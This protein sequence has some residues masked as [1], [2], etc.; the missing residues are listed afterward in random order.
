[1][2]AGARLAA[3]E[4]CALALTL[5]LVAA[6][7]LLSRTDLAAF[8]DRFAA[9]DG[10]VETSGAAALLAGAAL[11]GIRAWRSRRWR[12]ARF[13]GACALVGLGL[14]AA[15]GEELSWGQRLLRFAPPDLLARHNAQREANLH[16]LVIAGVQLK[17]FL[18]PVI[19]G[20][21]VAYLLLGP[22]AWLAAAGVRRAA[23]AGAVPVPRARHGVAFGLAYLMVLAIP[24]ARKW[25]MYEFAAEAVVAIAVAFPLN[26]ATFT[27]P[28]A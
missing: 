14:F 1:V 22:A 12:S 16:N 23:D 20:T 17:R 19:D 28:P 24:S 9:E 8:E 27:P 26:R 21:L 25:E 3:V 7:L 2:V 4:G 11:C 15:A 6:G 13:V 10:V 5:G 18:E